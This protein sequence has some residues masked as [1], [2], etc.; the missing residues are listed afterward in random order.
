VKEKKVV[1]KIKEIN[2]HDQGLE[3]IKEGNI[4]YNIILL[5]TY[6]INNLSRSDSRKHDKS[7]NL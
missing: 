2:I 1:K 3:N 4:K 6:K 5:K 7:R